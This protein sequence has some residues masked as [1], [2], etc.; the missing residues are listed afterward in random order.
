MAKVEFNASRLAR[1]VHGFLELYLLFLFKHK[2]FVA[3]S[4]W[5]HSKTLRAIRKFPAFRP[6]SVRSGI[7]VENPP[8]I[9]PS[10]VGAAYSVP[11]GLPPNGV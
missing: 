1:L 3:V 8:A 4:P 7:F 10:P 11:C 6:S 2:S 9:I 5:A